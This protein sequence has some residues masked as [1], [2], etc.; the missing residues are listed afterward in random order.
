ME[1][2]SPLPSTGLEFEKDAMLEMVEIGRRDAAAAHA[3]SSARAGHGNG[4]GLHI[5]CGGG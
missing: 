2:H 5:S 3:G 1:P 4:L